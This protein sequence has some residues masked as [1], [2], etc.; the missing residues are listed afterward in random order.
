MAFFNMFGSKEDRANIEAEK[1][2]MA[3]QKEIQREDSILKVNAPQEQTEIM[4]QQGKSD[5]LKWQQELDPELESIAHRFTGWFKKD[6]I[7]IKTNM[8]PLCNDRFMNDVVAPQL[9]PYLTKNLI[10]SNLTEERILS[11]LKH[12][13][14]DIMANMAD[15][16]DIYGINFQ[17]YDLILRVLKN[18]MKNSAFRALNGWTKKTDST[19]FKKL[20]SS[21]DNANAQQQRGLLGIRK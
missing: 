4:D 14:N 2:A 19:I 10:N 8:K 21:F 20:E 12:T 6:G 11:D 13:A 18:T 17:N 15:G 9:D 3:F 5:L 7:W 16:F 1:R